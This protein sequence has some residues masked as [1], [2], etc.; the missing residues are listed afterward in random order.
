[1]LAGFGVGSARGGAPGPVQG[2]LL[3]ESSRSL[4]RGFRAMAGAN[5][6]FGLLLLTVA[7]GLGIGSLGRG[8]FR[9][10]DLAG[11]T[12][13]LWLAVDG[14]RSSR[15]E[16]KGLPEASP[17]MSAFLRGVAAVLLN[18]GGWLFLGTVAGSL[19]AAAAADGGR[20]SAMRSAAA[21]LVGLG[22]GDA[23]VVVSGGIGLRRV[24]L[25]IRIWVQRA[26]A[27]LLAG[28]GVWLLV[29]GIT[30]K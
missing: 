11:G 1:M 23:T 26:L 29:Q 9:L 18:P 6:T 7:A 13:L 20:A 4:G 14:I 17:R 30:A 5:L 25:E 19:F 3:S 24:P 22:I 28:L 15:R 16:S 8:W 27:C 21:M 12:L 10:L 2:V